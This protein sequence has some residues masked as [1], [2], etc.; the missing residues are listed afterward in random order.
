MSSGASNANPTGSS[1]V[2]PAPAARATESQGLS[3]GKR[4]TKKINHLKQII[5]KYS[6]NM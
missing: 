4:L 6:T 5:E 2:N 1:N 3:S